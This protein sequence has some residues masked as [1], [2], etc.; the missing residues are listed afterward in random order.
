M[1]LESSVHPLCLGKIAPELLPAWIT[2]SYY[3]Y[4]IDPQEIQLSLPPNQTPRFYRTE[5]GK[6][7]LS[8]DSG[9][10]QYIKKAA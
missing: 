10:F 2:G 8:I 1:P 9:W 4:Y 6:A 5:K 3:N 7:L